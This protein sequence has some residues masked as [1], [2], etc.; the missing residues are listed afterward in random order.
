MN[1]GGGQLLDRFATWTPPMPASPRA[2]AARDSLA[3]GL[4]AY[5]EQR[6]KRCAGLQMNVC[7]ASGERQNV[8]DL[9]STACRDGQ[10]HNLNLGLQGRRVVNRFGQCYLQM[11]RTVCLSQHKTAEITASDKSHEIRL[12]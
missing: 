7:G 10:S 6:A 8:L 5:P 11:H 9:T 1:R 2:G 4:Q 3:L 12:N